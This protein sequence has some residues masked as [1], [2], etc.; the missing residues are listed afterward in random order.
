MDA[1]HDPRAKLLAVFDS[2]AELFAT[3][4]WRG[5]PFLA[6]NG[7]ARSGDPVSEV[8]ALTRDWTRALFTD[9]AARA[10]LPDP[11][12]MADALMNVYDGAIVASQFD[13]NPTAAATARRIA[14]VVITAA[15]R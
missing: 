8:T 12:A 13:H 10:G 15:E 1:A 14:E 5:C 11:A 7:E 4:N 2:Q 6:S 3:A 9:L